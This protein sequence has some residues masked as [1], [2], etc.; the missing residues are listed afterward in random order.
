MARSE[1]RKSNPIDWQYVNRLAEAGASGREIAATIGITDET[2]YKRTIKE[3][4]IHWAVYCQRYDEKGK[5]ALRLAQHEK[6]IIKQNVI[7]LIWLGKQRLNQYDRAALHVTQNE[8]NLDDLSLQELKMLYANPNLNLINYKD[9][10]TLENKEVL[11]NAE[12]TTANCNSDRNQETG[13]GANS[14]D[15]ICAQ[16]SEFC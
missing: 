10:K 1:G 4:N 11:Q 15:E 12:L 13:T 7:M 16:S 14:N 3:H 5:A 2:L 9:I 6:A 8:I